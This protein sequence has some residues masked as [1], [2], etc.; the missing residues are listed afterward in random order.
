MPPVV[1]YGT[2]LRIV[3]TDGSTEE[4][5]PAAALIAESSILR[6]EG[7][8]EGLPT[9]FLYRRVPWET[10]LQLLPSNLLEHRK[11]DQV[12]GESEYLMD[13]RPALLPNKTYMWRLYQACRNRALKERDEAAREQQLK[14]GINLGPTSLP[15]L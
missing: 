9:T 4:A 7:S 10:P 5:C 6:A 11:A 3:H 12:L 13:Q 14:S 15:P 8:I 2:R 1:V